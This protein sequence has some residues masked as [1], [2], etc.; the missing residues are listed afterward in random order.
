VDNKKLISILWVEM[1]SRI[2]AAYADT[3]GKSYQYDDQTCLRDYAEDISWNDDLSA[4]LGRESANE[5]QHRAHRPSVPGFSIESAAKLII[6][7]KIADGAKLAEMPKA[8]EFL[9]LRKTAAEA[10]LIGYLAR[11]FITPEWSK[12]VTDLDYAKLM[13]GAA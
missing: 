6:M 5:R 11:N 4:L 13:K 3:Q 9:I 2:N 7:S 10:R 1:R 12:T 8:T